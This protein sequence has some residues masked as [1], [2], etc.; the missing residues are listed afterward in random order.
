VDRRATKPQIKR[1]VESL[2]GVRVLAVRVQNR[3][4]MLRRNRFGFWQAKSMKR[5]VVQVHP[6]DRIELF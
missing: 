2:Y 6:D 4:G 3:K 1:A 5:A